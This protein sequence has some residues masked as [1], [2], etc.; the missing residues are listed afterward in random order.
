LTEDYSQW[1]IFIIWVTSQSNKLKS[2][3]VVL[4]RYCNF[5]HYDTDF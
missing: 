3:W 5:C 1:G 4:F 2:N